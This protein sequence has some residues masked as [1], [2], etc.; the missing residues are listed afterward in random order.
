MIVFEHFLR[1]LQ[2]VHFLMFADLGWPVLFN[3]IC[4]WV[5]V[6][7]VLLV[8]VA[9]TGLNLG[10]AVCGQRNFWFICLWLFNSCTLFFLPNWNVYFVLLNLSRIS[11]AFRK[12][13]LFLQD[14]L[15][16]S[17]ILDYRS[18]TH[19]I[20][21]FGSG[22]WQMRLLLNWIILLRKRLPQKREVVIDEILKLSG[23]LNLCRTHV[24]LMTTKL[25]RKRGKHFRRYESLLRC[26]WK[27]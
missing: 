19:Q 16:R 20:H 1:C 27:I 11:L 9:V 26:L 10:G 17:F 5:C 18:C 4:S 14:S 3:I 13:V 22:H 12:K 6:R 15:V 25:L 2:S 23:V 24:L 21:Y 7:N 8:L